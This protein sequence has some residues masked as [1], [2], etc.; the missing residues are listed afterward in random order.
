MG[1]FSAADAVHTV[2]EHL[3]LGKFTSKE[4]SAGKFWTSWSCFSAYSG[5]GTA[6]AYLFGNVGVRRSADGST[7][8]WE[9][10]RGATLEFCSIGIN[11]SA[12]YSWF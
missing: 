1:F 8:N 2:K 12:F 11:K 5:C 9:D 4:R 3:R 7:G 6:G 10:I